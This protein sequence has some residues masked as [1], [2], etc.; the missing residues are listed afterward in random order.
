MR[1]FRRL[2]FVTSASAVLAIAAAM[3]LFTPVEAS[4]GLGISPSKVELGALNP[5][6]VV[7]KQFTL[8]ATGDTATSVEVELL[9]FYL[10]EAG[11]QRFTAP[12]SLPNSSATWVKFSPTKLVIPAGQLGTVD[13][14]FIVPA[15]AGAGGHY[16]AAMFNFGAAQVKE[17][18]LAVQGAVAVQI[19]SQVTGN[20]VVQG[21]ASGGGTQA[22]PGEKA[23]T[24]VL[25]SLARLDLPFIHEPGPVAVRSRFEVRGN[26][27]LNV[28]ALTT[29]R[30]WH[31]Q[32]VAQ[33]VSGDYTVLP[34]SVKTIEGVW[35][36]P[37]PFGIFVAF[38]QVQDSSQKLPGEAFRYVFIIAPWKSIAVVLPFLIA[39]IWLIKVG[40]FGP[41]P[42]TPEKKA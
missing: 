21:T 38:M 14:E 20:I 16:A 24:G 1:T 29:I 37:P 5:G 4:T 31:G 28:K 12:G 26:A 15:N 19:L 13:F 41:K 23:D 6:T 36:N 35:D 30:D 25:S 10:D 33:I 40:F 32:D 17:G 34:N 2:R 42:V 18:S 9:D 22:A 11:E 39:S 3:L 8:R 7:R 27:H